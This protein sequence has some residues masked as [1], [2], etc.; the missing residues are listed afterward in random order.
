MKCGRSKMPLPFRI[1]WNRE[2]AIV[3]AFSSASVVGGLIGNRVLTQIVTPRA[4]GEL[5]LLMNLAHWLTIPTA[6]GYVYITRHWQVAQAHGSAHRFARA[7][8]W[9]LLAQTGVA[10]VGALALHLLGIGIASWSSLCILW[11]I[12]IAQAATQSLDPV[13]SMERRRVTAGL[14]GILGGPG[15]PFA[16]ALGALFIAQSGMGLLKAQAIYSSLLALATIA[17]FAWVL[18]RSPRSPEPSLSTEL[19]LAAFVAFAAPSLV[20]S[21]MTQA[22]A[23]AERWG[24]AELANPGATALFVQAVGLAT[25]VAGAATTF[26]NTYFLPL[27]T[28]HALKTA[29]PLRAARRP[30][31][32]YLLWNFFALAAAAGGIAAMSHSLTHLL[33]GPRFGS[34]GDLLPWTMVGAALFA[35]GQALQI[36]PFTA[37]EMTSP[38]VAFV[39]SKVAYVIVLLACASRGSGAAVLFA[40][41]YAT[42]SLLYAVAMVG[43]ATRLIRRE[44]GAVSH[45]PNSLIVDASVAAPAPASPPID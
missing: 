21:V 26:L 43:V 24:L 35:L 2:A 33:F 27:I 37:R 7:I 15:R 16:L 20:S 25:T 36:Y 29:T 8:G 4:L 42:G 38:N 1:R 45:G 3:V 44:R 10:G 41:V 30:I 28:Q 11:A 5:Y 14:L 32:A 40:K 6:A 39:L 31:Q 9:G 17:A 13:Q 22:C 19:T 12:C 34:V 23:S 18:W